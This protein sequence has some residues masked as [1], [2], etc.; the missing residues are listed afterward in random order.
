MRL[1]KTIDMKK[2]ISLLGM[3]FLFTSVYAQFPI[4]KWK[5]V[6]GSTLSLKNIDTD[7]L[8]EE[9]EKQPCLA[10]LIYTLT[11]DG[12]IITNADACPDSAK[13]DLGVA[14]LGIKWKSSA[15]NNIVITTADNDLELAYMLVSFT[16]KDTGRKGMLWIMDFKNEPD[17][18]NPDPIKR[19]IFTFHEL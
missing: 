14:D 11:A 15:Y 5:L 3:I 2:V 7:I 12:K 6:K 9:Y 17:T 19:L 16:N 4:G 18:Q 13:K 10:N 1:S 8:K